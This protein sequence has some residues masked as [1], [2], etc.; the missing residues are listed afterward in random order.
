MTLGE[1]ILRLRKESHMSQEELAECV[2]V[3]KQSVSKWELD[4]AVPNVEKV[5]RLCDVFGIS[6]DYL[7]KG[8]DEFPGAALESNDSSE[9]LKDAK[10]ERITEK[11]GGKAEPE[12][13]KV[14]KCRNLLWKQMQSQPEERRYRQKPWRALLWISFSVTIILM[15]VFYRVL[16]VDTWGSQKDSEQNLAIVEQIYT[17]YTLADVTSYNEESG[18]ITR[19]MLLDLDGVRE[20][21]YIYCY[22]DRE[23]PELVRYP[24]KSSTCI[25]IL[26]GFCMSLICTGVF[27]GLTWKGRKWKIKDKEDEEMDGYEKE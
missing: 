11:D 18:F 24:Y 7:L 4:K 6:T 26:T 3:S 14:S 27:A 10:E 16:I 19:R 12:E 2:E 17:Q 8:T 15:I 13:I 1:R 9:E 5:I 21:D 23:H 25:G 22:T 20:G